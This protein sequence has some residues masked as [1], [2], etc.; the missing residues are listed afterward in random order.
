[1]TKPKNPVYNLVEYKDKFVHRR[2]KYQINPKCEH[3]FGSK[4]ILKGIL[5]FWIDPNSIYNE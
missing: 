3:V 4:Y 2:K 5:N 1:M